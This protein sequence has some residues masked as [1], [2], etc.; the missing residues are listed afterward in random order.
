MRVKLKWIYKGPKTE[1]LVFES[2]WTSQN[3]MERIL[4]DLLRTG[5]AANLTVI[6]EMGNE[7]NRKEFL[8][9]KVVLEE[10]PHDIVVFFDGG[11][12]LE[13][14]KAGL[15]MVIYYQKGQKTY[16]IRSNSILQELDSNNEAEYA[17]LYNAILLLE[18]LGVKHTPCS[19]KGD[20][21]G[22]LKQLEGE[23]PCLEEN[24]NRWLDRIEKKIKELG[25]KASYT[26][27]SRK[28]NKEADQ[29]ASQALNNK[30]I[31]SHATITE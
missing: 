20:S 30:I 31:H 29:L 5:R 28:E 10:E 24:L 17:A 25:L 21:L 13:Q 4:E 26:P 7:W 15:G 11:Y 23:W 6:D 14:G 8:K 12:D 3:A 9:L 18:E 16:R 2:E 19:I 22:V 1:A 27:I